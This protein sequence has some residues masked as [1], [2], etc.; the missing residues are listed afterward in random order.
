MEFQVLSSDYII[1]F[2]MNLAKDCIY[3]K[4]Y[5]GIYIFLV[6]YADNILLANN[7]IGLLHDIKRF[8]IKNFE[9]NDFGYASFVFGI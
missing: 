5:R 2:E 9:M 8:L 6:L 3:H 7:D 1:Q 4:F